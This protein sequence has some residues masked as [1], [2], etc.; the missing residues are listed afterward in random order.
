MKKVLF[1]SALALV[2]LMSFSSCRKCQICTK[3]SEPEVRVCQ[4][5][6]KSNTEYG[7]AVDLLEG[8]G[9]NCR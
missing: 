4:G 3:S 8:G 9:Y 5:D 1:S 2:F 6:Y 7:L